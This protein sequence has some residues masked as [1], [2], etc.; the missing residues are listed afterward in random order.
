[1][2][3]PPLIRT[4]ARQRDTHRTAA[5]LDAQ[6][7]EA[8]GR[9]LVADL[10]HD[11]LQ[12]AATT[13]DRHPRL[14]WFA[15]RGVPG[16]AGFYC[17]DAT[18]LSVVDRPLFLG[19]AGGGRVSVRRLLGPS[20]RV[21]RRRVLR[22]PPAL[23]V[24]MPRHLGLLRLLHVQQRALPLQFEPLSQSAHAMISYNTYI[25]PQDTTETSER[26][27]LLALLALLTA[28]KV[29]VSSS[30]LVQQF[31]LRLF[32]QPKRPRGPSHAVHI[33]PTPIVKALRTW[34]C[35]RSVF[36]TPGAARH[37][38]RQKLTSASC[39]RSSI[40]RTATPV[41]RSGR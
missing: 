21:A 33:V 6:R 11:S 14:L 26:P 5:A 41:N 28:P 1:M 29:R 32:K 38:S 20:Y 35:S 16:F 36:V 15:I 27:N 7:E 8:P 37:L 19:R 2:S 13:T 34:I 24:S 22:S 9:L 23:G 39:S 40:Y 4:R 30:E 18:N 17:A 10:R 25:H 12:E 31:G 3:L